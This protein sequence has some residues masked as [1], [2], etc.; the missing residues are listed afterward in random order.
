MKEV[1]VKIINKSS[2]P[3]P[4][5]SKDGDACVDLRASFDLGW[6]G[7][8]SDKAE[9]DVVGNY[10]LIYPNGRTL[11]GTGLYV[12]FPEG[13]MLKLQERSGLGSK[14]I[15]LSGG[16]IDSNYRGEIKV[17]LVNL[18][19]EVFVVEHG[20]R[21]A[22]ACLV[23]VPKIVWDEVDALEET[24]RGDKGFNSTGVK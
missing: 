11:I 1:E 7:E 9:Y 19:D 5:Y 23:E 6:N 3:L 16:V 21:I 22:Q 24:E 20:D 17:A 4:T 8:N 10:L 18:S 13:Y 2:N 14:G 15:K 12:S